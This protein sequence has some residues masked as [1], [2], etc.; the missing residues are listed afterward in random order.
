[1][2]PP[3]V[4]PGSHPSQGRILAIGLQA[5]KIQTKKSYKSWGVSVIELLFDF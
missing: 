2:D 4:E 1:M 5:H 3:G